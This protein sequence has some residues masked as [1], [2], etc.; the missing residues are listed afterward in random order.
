MLSSPRPKNL[1]LA[2]SGSSAAPLV[3][4]NLLAFR[5][6]RSMIFPLAVANFNTD[7]YVFHA[8]SRETRRSHRAS[9]ED[10]PRTGLGGR[11]EIR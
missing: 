3:R 10:E 9:V 11:D 8:S 5:A 2:V 7:K 6:R 4:L 1:G